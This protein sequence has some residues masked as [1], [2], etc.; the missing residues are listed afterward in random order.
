M[1]VDAQTMID[2]YLEAE[3]AVLFGKETM[4]NGRKAVMADLPAIRAGRLEW[5]RRLNSQL[6]AQQGESGFSLAEF[7]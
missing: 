1:A 7:S 5:E 4:F 3:R 6:R 2:H